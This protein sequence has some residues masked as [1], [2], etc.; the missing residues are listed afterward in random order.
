MR[1]WRARR[2]RDEGVVTAFVVIFAVVLIFTCGLVLDGGRTLVA[3]REAR[4]AADAAARAGAQALDEEAIRT[5]SPQLLD[6]VLARTRACTMLAHSGFDCGTNADVFTGADTVTVTV[7]SDVDMWLL[8]GVTSSFD[9][10][11]SACVVIGIT[12]Q[13]PSAQC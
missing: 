1:A 7:S 4:N 8:T 13:E 6:P 12:G 10:E 9:V 3:Y 11:G 5:H 2:D